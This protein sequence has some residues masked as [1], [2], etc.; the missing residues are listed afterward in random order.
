MLKKLL[1]G[2][3]FESVLF[4]DKKMVGEP[5]QPASYFRIFI[6]R[7]FN[8]SASYNSD[9]HNHITDKSFQIVF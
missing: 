9:I 1:Y 3:F 5:V 7:C 4:M 2:K 6:F 8:F